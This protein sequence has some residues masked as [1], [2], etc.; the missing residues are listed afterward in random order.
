LKTSKLAVLSIL[1]AL[2]VVFSFYPGPVPV[3]PTFVFPFQSMINVIAGILLGPWYAAAVALAVGTIRMS[4]HTGTVFSLPGGIPGAMLV[5]LTYKATKSY[6]SAFAEIPG[7]A[8]VGAFLS[9]FLVA[10]II[11][12]SATLGFFVLA[13][14]PPAV[15]G[16]VIGYII[17]IALRK[18]GI[19][20]RV[21]L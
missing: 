5:G 11:G 1:T 20:A 2:G 10:P 19:I 15:L 8:L 16:S 17:M 14:T 3:G 18:R 9:A 4:A 6:L 12:S 21:P 13:F 7:T